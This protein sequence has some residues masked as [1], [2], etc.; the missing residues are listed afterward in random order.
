MESRDELIS[1][2]HHSNNPKPINHIITSSP[3]QPAQMEA[4]QPCKRSELRAGPSRRRREVP[5]LERRL[6][7]HAPRIDTRSDIQS[8]LCEPYS[9]PLSESKHRTRVL[10]PRLRIVTVLAGAPK[11]N[12]GFERLAYGFMLSRRDEARRQCAPSSPSLPDWSP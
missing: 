3:L 8:P 2:Q 7:K 1:S 6:T 5:R 10:P 9:L 11:C 4:Q 12:L